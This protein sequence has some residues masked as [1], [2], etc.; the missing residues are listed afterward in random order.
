MSA[1][2]VLGSS[3]VSGE[4]LPTG[5]TITPTAAQ[6]ALFQEMNLN[7]QAAP[8][9]RAGAAVA[10]A[11]SADGK[12]LAIQTGGFNVFYGR[13]GQ[14]TP[15]L[16]AEHI[17]LFDI[18]GPAPKQVQ[19][20]SIP[21][22]FQGLA[23]G[24]SSDRLYASTGTEDAITE[25]ERHGSQFVTNRTFRLGH[26][27]GLGLDVVPIAAGIA[28]SP[29]GTRL[30]VANLQND[31]ISL[32]DLV[33]G[34]LVTEQDLR[35]GAIEPRHHGQPGGSFPRSVAWTSDSRAYIAS[36][37]DREVISVAVKKDAVRLL[38]RIAVNGQPVALL[39]NRRGTRLYVA[40]DTTSQ[41]AIVDTQREEVIESVDTTAPQSVYDNTRMLGGA[42]TNALALTPDEATLLA[43]DGG[44]NA[45]AVIRLGDRARDPASAPHAENREP[46]ETEGPDFERSRVV[47]LVPTGWYPTGIAVSKDS[48]AWYVIN[49][50]SPT[51][52]NA[53]WC[54]RVDPSLGIC[55]PQKSAG[56]DLTTAVNGFGT[57]LT[58]N[59]YIHQLEKAGL[60]S[61]P[62][63][64][65]LELARLTQQVAHNDHFDRP[66]KTA[67]DE[68]ITHFL[69]GHIKHV[70][71]IIKENRTYDQ[72]LGDLGA[73]NGDPRLTLFPE[74]ISPNHHALARNFVTLD[75]LLLS[76]EVSW[77]GWDFA[78]AG[79]T[80][81]FREHQEPLAMRADTLR[82]R[83]MP[84]DNAT[85]RLIN[86]GYP[87]S[88]QRRAVFS[89]SPSDPDILPGT[90]S[91]YAPDG[92]GGEEGK[93]YLWDVALR[94]GK[95]LRNWG[96]FG[97]Q[98]I[99]LP[100][101]LPLVRDP[102]E[103]K[104]QLFY[105]AQASLAP[106]S[107]L[108][109]AD[110]TMAYPD[111][112]RVKEWKREFAGFVQR[113]EA[114]NLMMVWLPNDHFGFFDQAIDGVNTPDT[115]MADNDYALGLVIEAV[116]NSPFAKDTVVISIEDD[117]CD[118]PDHV[119]AHRSVV[120]FAGP[121]VRQHAVISTRYTTVS[122]VRTIEEILGIGPIGLNDAL[123][124]PMSDVF[125]P[126][127]VDWTY[128]AIVPNVLRST[129]LPLPPDSR[130]RVSYPRHS[131][132]Y[133]TKAM[134]GQD[135]S[136]P[137]R[138]DPVTFNRAL[139]R[140]FKGSTAY[141]G[142]KSDQ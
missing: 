80:T 101:Q 130:A 106:Y 108:Y 125:D 128:K 78:V 66:G 127:Q 110:V 40:L 89:R 103:Q 7:S 9:A 26:S 141:P 133:W 84:E 111:F 138:I 8:N 67:A 69:Q 77:T 42:N 124:A 90:R 34:A 30:L 57:L 71:Y 102:Y 118:G 87:D 93:G 114:P 61:F 85:N 142:A 86:M 73:G 25:F 13:D 38:R 6:G 55:I 95:T 107:D 113:G 92:A 33:K 23:W 24:A 46:N 64:G 52:S 72:V 79:Q 135:F 122:V 48:S 17:F 126:R 2:Q 112:W 136:G 54:T 10:L 70:I 43:S 65:P 140:G 21:Q 129:R 32:I 121:Y 18:A 104:I 14:T 81:D 100:G 91:V 139:W 19:V 27:A 58:E 50:K 49:A 68:R 44:E 132:A 59:Q 22:G 96:V 35:P 109:F 131:A 62:A 56:P 105:P 88:A 47:A 51:G 60:L 29:D 20:L 63:P 15:D 83:G 45:V 31:S 117:A 98:Q 82:M 115:Q 16:S 123:A 94:A 137:D 99:Q 12:L 75:N 5:K 37:R 11:V 1:A 120:L 28:I 74:R 116:A 4:D 53:K 39:S 41:V 97:D 134:A 76:G 3:P 119:D 36:E